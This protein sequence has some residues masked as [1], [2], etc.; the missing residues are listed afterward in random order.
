MRLWLYS[1]SCVALSPNHFDSSPP[2]RDGERPLQQEILLWCLDESLQ[3]H[4]IQIS[5]YKS[6]IFL[7]PKNKHVRKLGAANLHNINVMFPFQ[8]ANMIHHVDVWHDSRLFIGYTHSKPKTVIRV[9]LKNYARKKDVCDTL[10]WKNNMLAECVK[11]KEVLN[12]PIPPTIQFLYESGLRLQSWF[13]VADLKKPY[14]TE[15]LF[16]QGIKHWMATAKV[17]KNDDDKGTSNAP[18]L[19]KIFVRIFAHSFRATTTN[20]FEPS[21]E[22][23]QDEVRYIAYVI[24]GQKV[25]SFDVMDIWQYTKGEAGLL[26]AF[27]QLIE[28]NNIQVMVFAS[29]EQVEPNCLVY[30]QKRANRYNINLH[31]SKLTTMKHACEVKKCNDGAS[32]FLDFQHPGVERMDLCEVLKKAMVNPPL[33]GFTMIDALRHPKLIR[34]KQPFSKLL[35]LNYHAIHNFSKH[36]II[37]TDLALFV[38]L[39]YTLERDNG[40]CIG[41]QNLSH[42]CDLDF[43]SVC[44]RGQQTRVR[45]LFCRELFPKH[46]VINAARSED[47]YIVVDKLQEDSAFPNP[48][49]LYNPPRE[50]MRS[51]ELPRHVLKQRPLQLFLDKG[52]LKLPHNNILP[53]EEKEQPK[54]DDAIKMSACKLPQKHFG[55]VILWQGD[56][57]T[58]KRKFLECMCRACKYRLAEC[59]QS[60]DDIG[61]TWSREEAPETSECRCTLEAPTMLSEAKEDDMHKFREFIQACCWCAKCRDAIRTCV[62]NCKLHKIPLPWEEAHEES[63]DEM[64]V[65]EEIEQKTEEP[66][67]PTQWWQNKYAADFEKVKKKPTT[68]AKVVNKKRYVGGLVLK[69]Q[70]GF[71]TLDEDAAGTFDFAS[72]YPSAMQGYLLCYMCVI[73][74]KKWLEDKRLKV[75]FIPLNPTECVPFA[76][77]YDGKPAETALPD[78]VAKIV[79]LRKSTR[80]E[81]ANYEEGS[82]VWVALE[83]RQL[84]AKVVQ[85]SVYGFTGSETSGMTC[86]AIAAA[87]T[88]IG[89]WMNRIVQYVILFLGGWIFYGDTDSVMARCHMLL[90][91]ITRDE[92]LGALYEW[93]FMV[94]KFCTSLFAPPNKLEF[95]AVKTM[96]LLLKKK[97]YAAIHLVTAYAKHHDKS[98][99]LWNL[100]PEAKPKI[101]GMAAK[102][103]DKAELAQNAGMGLIKKLL[104]E[105]LTDQDLVG[106]YVKQLKAIQEAPIPKTIEELAPYIVT[107]ALNST[108]KKTKDVL[109]LHLADMIQQESGVRPK[110]GTRLAY[111]KS[112]SLN[113]SKPLHCYYCETPDHHLANKNEVDK[114]YIIETQ[115]YNCVKQVLSLP[116]HAGLLKM[117]EK[118]TKDAG[119]R[120]RNKATGAREITQFFKRQKT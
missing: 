16:D 95:E 17:C 98:V 84:A 6:P 96:F 55:P 23:P 94:Q 92:I 109:A 34:D 88:N 10:R 74:K 57:H 14:G 13:E 11:I 73:Y 18:T 45:D 52:L 79:K 8:V 28:R 43:T 83:S 91:W 106:W 24:A 1:I 48:E 120:C 100:P 85:N 42:I 33:D 47:R 113:G 70:A 44:E 104:Y 72:L 87:T 60:L 36:D 56:I 22:L 3:Q 82:F 21:D 27:G 39:L 54:K 9:F 78:I 69:A 32:S 89:Q 12:K 5:E 63:D 4:V 68:R 101:M 41:Q 65:E 37:R 35:H 66:K 38:Q 53:P 116:E 112:T 102:K 115:I 76:E 25:E 67:K 93:C 49:Q 62:R 119:H 61:S 2:R 40:Y 46:I 7:L 29:D 20:Q 90:K 51:N 81:Q 103:R 117:F 97:T 58:H 19:R 50:C 71:W 15:N 30:L 105:R 99:K 77:S 64:D 111:V 75:R 59:V 107:C 80:L 86:T 26:Y 114:A 118:A 110:P 31:F 108:Y